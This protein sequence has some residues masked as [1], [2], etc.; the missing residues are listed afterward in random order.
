MSREPAWRSSASKRAQATV[1]PV[2]ASPIVSA[3]VSTWSWKIDGQ[4]HLDA[5]HHAR[6]PYVLA[7][8]HGRILPGLGWLRH[9]GLVALASENFDGEWIARVLERYGFTMVRGSSSRGGVKAL[10]RLA[11]AMREG[12]STV[13]TVDGPRGP[14]GRAQPGAVWV[15]QRVHAP[16]IPFHI[17]SSRHWTLASWDAGQIPKPFA[18]VTVCIGPPLW[19]PAGDEPVIEAGRADLEVALNACRDR[20]RQ[21]AGA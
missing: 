14:A 12:R 16:I 8:W 9:R 20:A 21:L 19:I 15:A 10:V 6:Q 7:V 2:V 13:I 3:L 18:R 5:L 11:A 1:I 4:H 17:E